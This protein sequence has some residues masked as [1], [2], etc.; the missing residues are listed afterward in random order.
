VRARYVIGKLATLVVVML[1]VSLVT[2]LL[3][4]LLP[5]DPAVA[6]VGQENATEQ[7]LARVRAE[8]R[9]DDPLPVRYLAWLGGVVTGDLGTSYQTRQP[10]SSAIAAAFPV[11]AELTVLALV[12][13]LPALPLALLA[14]R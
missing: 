9:L 11:T 1:V 8:L 5:G 3:L 14:A 13:S 2:F 4:E 7:N 10:V 6:I 12:L